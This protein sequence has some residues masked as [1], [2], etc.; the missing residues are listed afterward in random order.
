MNLNAHSYAT[1]IVAVPAC[2]ARISSEM[3]SLRATFSDIEKRG[4]DSLVL[5]TDWGIGI[6]RSRH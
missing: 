2:I 3:I 1:A 6:I 4:A 5:T